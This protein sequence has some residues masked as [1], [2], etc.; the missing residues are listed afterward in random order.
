SERTDVT[1]SREHTLKSCSG[2]DLLQLLAFPYSCRIEL[3]A[4][5]KK[6]DTWRHVGPLCSVGP[7]A[8]G[9]PGH[10]GSG[11]ASGRAPL[12]RLGQR[13]ARVLG[14]RETGV[15]LERLG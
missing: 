5:H 14:G 7:G 11:S 9:P 10:A 15:Q 2:K 13:S 12:P 1:D 8:S 4:N 6:Q 3:V